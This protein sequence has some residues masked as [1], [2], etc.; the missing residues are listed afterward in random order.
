MNLLDNFDWTMLVI[1]AIAVI[2][3]VSVIVDKLQ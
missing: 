2:L 1:A 3:I